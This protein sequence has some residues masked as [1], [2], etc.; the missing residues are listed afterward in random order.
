MG[1][2]PEE[3]KP[4]RRKMIN[5]VGRCNEEGRKAGEFAGYSMGV[6]WYGKSI[7]TN[8]AGR[9]GTGEVSRAFALN[10]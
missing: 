9:T 6:G 2:P 8:L 4:N 3:E 5:E 1:R 10:G 7:F